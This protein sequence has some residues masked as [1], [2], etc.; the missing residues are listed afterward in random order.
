MEGMALLRRP[1]KSMSAKLIFHHRLGGRER[2]TM[3]E[4]YVTTETYTTIAAETL[5]IT[6]D[7]ALIR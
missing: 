1:S 2:L 7:R 6:S 3:V 4:M 5:A